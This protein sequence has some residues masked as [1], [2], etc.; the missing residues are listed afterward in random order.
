MRSDARCT[1]K[2]ERASC[3]RNGSR[4]PFLFYIDRGTSR[5]VFLGARRNQTA[6]PVMPRTNI[7]L[8]PGRWNHLSKLPTI[9]RT[10][11]VPSSKGDR[12]EEILLRSMFF[13]STMSRVKAETDA[14]T[15]VRLANGRCSS[16]KM[17]KM[18]IREKR[19]KKR[20]SKK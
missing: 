16:F 12:K 17:R 15:S 13:R 20:N 5:R 14:A 7:I 10:M 19:S 18:T 6:V 8:A 1:G 4:G 3:Y 9:T 2:C 11:E